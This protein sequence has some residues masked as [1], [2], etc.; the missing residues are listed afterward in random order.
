LLQKTI[1]VAHLQK[2]LN[3]AVNTRFLI[4]NKMEGI[5]RFTFETLKRISQANPQHRF[6]CIFDR[7]PHKQFLFSENIIPVIARPPARH[8][9]LW[10]WWFELSVPRILKKINADIFISPDGFAS[11]KTKVPQIT[12]MHDIAFEHY[13]QFIPFLTRKYYRYYSPK[14]AHKVQG[15]A[16]VSNFSKQD[17]SVKYNIDAAK[18][19][20]VYNGANPSCQP[21]NEVEKQKVKK[22]YSQDCDYFVFISAVHP[23]KNLSRIL[24]AFDFF[25]NKTSSTTKLIVAGRMAWKNENLKT[26]YQ[27]MEHQ[28][29][30]I[31]V[32]HLPIKEIE[33][34]IASATAL[35]YAS[36]FEG[37][38]LPILEAMYAETP[39]ITSNVSSMPEVAGNAALLVDPKNVESISEAFV[40]LENQPELGAKLVEA[41]KLQR[42][43]FT[44]E[45]AAELLWN[46][47]E[48]TLR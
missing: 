18:I 7:P 13:P 36:L 21:L 44:W 10:Y 17:I 2:A 12:V 29:E 15:I 40:K 23:R 42:Q 8:P 43:K 26:I 48:K 1:F 35:C 5:G 24:Q 31:F 46:I 20:V 28:Q 33:R 27:K 25:K 14:Y 22:K 4:H 47:V 38:G 37:F 45:R 19:D 34:L 3:I 39:V 11:L 30:V 32:G 16:T 41:G 9:V 6:Y